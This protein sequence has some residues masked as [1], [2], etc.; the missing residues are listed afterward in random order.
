MIL[1]NTVLPLYSKNCRTLCQN[2]RNIIYFWN[3]LNHILLLLIFSVITYCIDPIAQIWE[4]EQNLVGGMERL[5]DL[6]RKI[7]ENIPS[8]NKYYQIVNMDEEYSKSVTD[9]GANIWK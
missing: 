5:P 1:I 7:I 4:N 9:N 2:S 3:Q 6:E 8:S